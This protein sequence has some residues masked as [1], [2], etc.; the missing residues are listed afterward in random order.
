MFELLYDVLECSS[1]FPG[2]VDGDTSWIEEEVGS[3]IDGTECLEAKESD[4]GIL[5]EISGENPGL[6]CRLVTIGC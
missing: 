5:S 2:D 4:D 6:T 3:D 1:L